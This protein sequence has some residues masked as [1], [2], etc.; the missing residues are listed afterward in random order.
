[1]SRVQQIEITAEEAGQRLDRWFLRQLEAV[2]TGNQEAL[3]QLLPDPKVAIESAIRHLHEPGIN[4]VAI[5]HGIH[6]LVRRKG[7]WELEEKLFDSLPREFLETLDQRSLAYHH[8]GC[9][10]LALFRRNWSSAESRLRKAQELARDTGDRSLRSTRNRNQNQ[11]F[12]ELDE[13]P[14]IHGSERTHEILRGSG[15][16]STIRKKRYGWT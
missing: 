9:G 6:N 3:R 7:F 13:R 2:G 15:N 8:L 14:C 1:M 10:R 11:L 4:R 16:M 5:Q 12:R